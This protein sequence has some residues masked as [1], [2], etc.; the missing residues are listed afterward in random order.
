MLLNRTTDWPQLLTLFLFQT[1][2]RP[3]RLKWAFLT[4]QINAL[5]SRLS[6]PER[7][8][9]STLDAQAQTQKEPAVVN[10]SV[11]TGCKQHQKNCPQICK[12]ACSRPVWIGPLTDVSPFFSLH[13]RHTDEH[14]YMPQ[15]HLKILFSGEKHGYTHQIKKCLHLPNRRA[16]EQ[17]IIRKSNPN[18]I[19]AAV[20]RRPLGLSVV[21]AL[22]WQRK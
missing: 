4:Q 12:L 14:T 18:V 9:Q 21:T 13:F 11:Y 6:P 17:G 5:Q 2:H 20:F 1:P 8:A 22:L 16:I 19:T 15:K 7:K 3:P 10:G